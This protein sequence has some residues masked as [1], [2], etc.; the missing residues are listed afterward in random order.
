MISG[1]RWVAN[2]SLGAAVRARGIHYPT[3]RRQRNFVGDLATGKL[4]LF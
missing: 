1:F 3:T 4:R 2:S